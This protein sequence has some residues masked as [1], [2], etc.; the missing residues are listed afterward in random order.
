MNI[1]VFCMNNWKTKKS[2]IN[3]KITEFVNWTIHFD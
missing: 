2:V 1:D 3:L